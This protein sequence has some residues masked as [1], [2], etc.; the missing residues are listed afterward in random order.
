MRVL[1][2]GASGFLG[3]HLVSVLLR[4][5]VETVAVCRDPKNASL[6][7]DALLTKVPCDLGRA[8]AVTKLAER[9]GNIDVIYHSAAVT[10]GSHAEAML[11]TVVGSRNLIEAFAEARPRLVLV[12]SFSVY[13]LTTLRRWATLD[14]SAPTED[15]LRL[16]D[17]Y[18]VTKTRQERLVRAECERRGIPLTVVRPGKIY[19]PGAYPL[20][21]QLGLRL[22]GIA[23]LW[24][25]GGHVLPLTHVSNCAEA[26]YLAGIHPEAVGQTINLVD[27]DL[28]TQ[29]AFMKLYRSCCGRPKRTFWIP[30]SVFGLFVR[31]MERASRTSKGNIPPLLT[32]YRAANLWKPL[33]YSNGR[34]RQVLGW[35]P[36]IGWVEGVRETLASGDARV[37]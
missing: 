20:P 25:G 21:P 9:T 22:P 37:L 19:G 12:S 31:V 29:R 15:N 34:A 16:R 23:Y 13:K 35:T 24:M 27:D 2:T 7:A 26:V 36:R 11:G 33:T 8:D 17:S 30:D 6:P 14:E 18:T 3:Q 32:R 4:E 1:V 28:P 5:G 10:S